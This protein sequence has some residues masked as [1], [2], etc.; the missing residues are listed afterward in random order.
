MLRRSINLSVDVVVD[1]EVHVDV[2]SRVEHCGEVK[3]I[4]KVKVR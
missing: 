3:V 1:V 4:V 2:D